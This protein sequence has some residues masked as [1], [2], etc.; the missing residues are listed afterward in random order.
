[1]AIPTSKPLN[2]STVQAEYGGSNPISM[3]EYRGDGNAPL[4]GAI[5]LWAD[6]NGTSGINTL[7][8]LFNFDRAMEVSRNSSNA[9]Y[10]SPT[11]GGITNDSAVVSYFSSSTLDGAQTAFSGHH[12]SKLRIASEPWVGAVITNV[13]KADIRFKID[14]DT[15]DA[16]PLGSADSRHRLSY[17]SST[18]F[19]GYYSAIDFGLDFNGGDLASF[20]EGAVGN[21]GYDVT[22]SLSASEVAAWISNGCPVWVGCGGEEIDADPYFA[23]ATAGRIYDIDID[24][25]FTYE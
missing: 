13:T 3:S 24:L 25:A 19:A 11:T 21:V 16:G 8:Q 15:A 1:M 7:D 2:L 6:F 14:S 20:A 12:A 9:P 22:S 23:T 17:A 5:D 10:N 18:A 4:S